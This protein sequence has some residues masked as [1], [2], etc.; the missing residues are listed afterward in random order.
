MAAQEA[1][2][3]KLGLFRLKRG[4][5]KSLQYQFVVDRIQKFGQLVLTRD[6]KFINMAQLA[7]SILTLIGE[8]AGSDDK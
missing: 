1:L 4:E 5:Q 2:Y 8:D 3:Q 7:R 6:D